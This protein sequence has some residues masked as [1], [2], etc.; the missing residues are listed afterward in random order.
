LEKEIIQ[1]SNREQCRL[2][3]DL[4]DSLGQSL[5]GIAFLSNVLAQKLAD[6]SLKEAGDAARVAEL[7]SQATQK[8]RHI[9]KGLSPVLLESD[10]LVAALEELASQTEVLF[11]VSCRFECHKPFSFPD[12]SRSND[13][14]RIAQE[15]VNN[16]IKHAKAKH[17]S[18]E[19]IAL[20]TRYVL[21]IKDDGIGLPPK[22]KINKGMGIHIMNYRARMIGGVLDVRCRSEGGTVVTCSFRP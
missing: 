2:G 11:N 21:I 18:I 9:T 22:L 4:H 8:I 1:I 13:L 17:I 7:I 19:L 12:N 5:T 10:G 14:Y 3:H 6:K 16:A 20:P 15:A